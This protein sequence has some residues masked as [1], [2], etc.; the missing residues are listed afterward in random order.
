MIKN[1]LIALSTAF[2]RDRNIRRKLLFAFTLI[3]LLF[4]VCGSFVIDNLLKGAAGQA[5]QN[6]N[7]IFDLPE[8]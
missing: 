6:M 1:Q 7:L 2:L 4:S 5:I 8:E 3:T